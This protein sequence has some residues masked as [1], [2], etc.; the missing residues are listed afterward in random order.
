V[1]PGTAEDQHQRGRAVSVPARMS[2]G[3]VAS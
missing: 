1:G 2:N 3:V